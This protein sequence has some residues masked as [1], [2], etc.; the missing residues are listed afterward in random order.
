M[1]WKQL[2]LAHWEKL[3]LGAAGAALLATTATALLGAGGG[4]AGERVA[5][6]DRLA[7]DVRQRLTET[8]AP[9]LAVRSYG[10]ATRDA[11]ASVEAAD[12]ASDWTMYYPTRIVEL[13]IQPPPPPGG[14]AGGGTSTEAEPRLFPPELSV[15][16]VGPRALALAWTLPE[17]ARGVE[18]FRIE[19]RVMASGPRGAGRPTEFAPVATVSDG[20]RTFSDPSATPDT[21]Y[22]YRVI[23]V[24]N[25]AAT[26]AGAPRTARTPSD[27]RLVFAGGSAAAAVIRIERAAGDGLPALTHAFQVKVGEAV[28]GIVRLY[29]N[30]KPTAVDFGTGLTL[31]AL[32]PVDLPLPAVLGRAGTRSVLRAELTAP[33]GERTTLLPEGIGG[34]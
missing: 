1:D 18:R 33:G 19:R 24:A 32:G 27:L 2:G 20:E 9:A 25:N 17:A 22:A 15:T 12:P 34:V 8:R 26:A 5:Q 7:G 4:A 28:G 21:T 3:G 31:T 16:A 11:W 10:D 6:M 13:P 23:A 29:V 30:G 14:G